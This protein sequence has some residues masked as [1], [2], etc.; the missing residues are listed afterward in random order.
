MGCRGGAAAIGAVQLGD[1]HTG[2]LGRQHGCSGAVHGHLC[3]AFDTVGNIAKRRLDDD[4]LRACRQHIG[5]V[6]T[7]GGCA[8]Q[9]FNRPAHDLGRGS[10]HALIDELDGPA[11]DKAQ[12]IGIAR[13]HD[14]AFAGPPVCRRRRGGLVQRTRPA[15]QYIRSG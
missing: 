14:V 2:N 10:R 3:R 6:R 15:E 12:H 8:V 7:V 1:I 11:V 5:Q 13:H 9:Q 4:V